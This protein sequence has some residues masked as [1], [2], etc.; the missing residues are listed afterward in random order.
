[1]PSTATPRNAEPVTWAQYQGR[2][3][4]RRADMRAKK[5]A[6]RKINPRRI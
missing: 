4:E 2:H 3:A 6:R 1:M 5:R